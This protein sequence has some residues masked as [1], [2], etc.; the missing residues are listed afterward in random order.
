MYQREKPR[1]RIRALKSC[2]SCRQRKRKCDQVKPICGYCKDKR[3]TC[4]YQE[5]DWNIKVSDV[6]RGGVKTITD[7]HNSIVINNELLS[8]ST[9]VKQLE[10]ALIQQQQV[11]QGQPPPP[12]PPPPQQCQQ[13]SELITEN[14]SLS[15]PLDLQREKSQSEGSKII[16]SST[17]TTAPVSAGK[18][19]MIE[20]IYYAPKTSNPEIINFHSDNFPSKFALVPS[21]GILSWVA[22]LRKDIY[23]SSFSVSLKNEKV[24]LFQKEKE[25]YCRQLNSSK[26]KKTGPGKSVSNVNENTQSPAPTLCQ[27]NQG[28]VPISATDK[29]FIDKY[30]D[31]AVEFDPHILQK[32]RKEI[33][34]LE[35]LSSVLQDKKLIW[36]LIGKFFDSELYYVLPILNREEFT[37]DLIEI[38]GSETLD[39]SLDKFNIKKRSDIAV[40]GTL[41]IIM[42]LS[43][44]SMYNCGKP[45]DVLSESD[46][47]ILEHPIGLDAMKVV[48]RCINAIQNYKISEIKILQLFLMKK[49]YTFYSPEDAD[50]TTFADPS[51]LGL[52][53]DHS[54]RCGINRDPTLSRDTST[55]ANLIRRL[56]H[57]VLYLDQHQLMLV[58][59]PSLIDSRYHDTHF[60][61]LDQS[62]NMFELCINKSILERAET[63]NKCYPLLMMILDVRNS[64]KISD[65]KECL[66]HLQTIINEQGSF[67][68]IR[69]LDSSSIENRTLKLKRF[70]TKIDYASLL[71]IIYYHFF[72]FYNRKNDVSNSIYYLVE[73]IRHCNGFTTLSL[74]LDPKFPNYN[75]A[76]DFSIPMLL[77][78]RI[79]LSLH[80]TLQLLFSI[81]GR[82]NALIALSTGLPKNIS[83]I[84]QNICDLST[85]ISKR[86]VSRVQNISDAY[87]HCWVGSKVQSFIVR[88]LMQF[89]YKSESHVYQTFVSQLAALKESDRIVFDYSY[90]DF[91]KI[92]RALV[93]LDG[94]D[95]KFTNTEGLH[96]PNFKMTT[97]NAAVTSSSSK[98]TTSTPISQSNHNSNGSGLNATYASLSTTSIPSLTPTNTTP[99]NNLTTTPNSTT[100]SVSN[101]T[102][103][104]DGLIM[105]SD[106]DRIWLDQMMNGG[107]ASTGVN[108]SSNASNNNR[109]GASD[110]EILNGQT[111]SFHDNIGL[112]H[113]NRNLRGEP[114]VNNSFEQV[115]LNEFMQLDD[116]G[117]NVFGSFF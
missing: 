56:W 84:A 78:P 53:L 1:K 72:I 58:G 83:E 5:T 65:V 110:Y 55:S 22:L 81:C 115:Q 38:I 35:M 7:D 20:P 60:P 64:P 59:C 39:S 86:L 57:Q 101:T 82:A 95:K 49:C 19:P 88:N 25:A 112:D 97:T 75:L 80:R 14:S 46:N 67:E 116:A 37:K 103:D 6:Q 16:R 32:Q 3:F 27:Q 13:K 79:E 48:N 8:I 102:L 23:L 98:R 114:A 91:L 12:P 69:K 106:V 24:K 33:T 107:A 111:L 117:F 26:R 45:H 10:A 43:S 74:Y 85:K 93:E 92:F 31:E 113:M 54:F 41:I 66:V 47:Y 108:S 21:H 109:M 28:S 30:E 9:R 94:V 11:T 18:V 15:S 50:C 73:L 90:E 62:E 70:Y 52:L 96:N 99:Q 2:L 68:E 34:L 89:G 104:D 40:I 61:H 44:C 71:F 51:S 4:H 77:I 105:L 36:L 29:D 76:N 87:Y 63:F 100:T 17:H 42:R